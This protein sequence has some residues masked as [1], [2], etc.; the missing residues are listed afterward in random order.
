MSDYP[1]LISNKLHSFRNFN[2]QIYAIFS[3]V[4]CFALFSGSYFGVIPK[5][6]LVFQDRCLVS[7][8]W[9]NLYCQLLFLVW[10]LLY[11]HFW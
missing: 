3:Y 9:Y 10:V 7:L 11:V 2:M 5:Y 4:L 1:M 6:S 8:L